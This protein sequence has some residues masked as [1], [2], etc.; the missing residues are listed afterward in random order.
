MKGN[1]KFYLQKFL[2]DFNF[3]TLYN[4]SSFNSQHNRLLKEAIILFLNSLIKYLKCMT[5]GLKK[6]PEIYSQKEQHQITLLK[7]NYIP[8]YLKLGIF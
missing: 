6:L 8:T 2:K 3:V 5:N 7:N 1:I 4:I